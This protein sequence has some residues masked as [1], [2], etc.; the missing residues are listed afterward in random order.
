RRMLEIAPG[1]RLAC[2]NVLKQH[3][4]GLDTTVDEQGQKKNVKRLLRLKHGAHPLAMEEGR[5]TFH[6][7][8]ATDTAAALLD[9]AR[10]NL[11][12]HIVLGARTNSLLPPTL[13]GV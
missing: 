13:G 10:T 2:L 12:D 1:T 5:I 8:E 7:L 4:I 11:V 6:V 3:R 9:Y